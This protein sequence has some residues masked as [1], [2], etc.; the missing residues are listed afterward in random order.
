METGCRMQIANIVIIILSLSLVTTSSFAKNEFTFKQALLLAYQKNPDLCVEIEKANAMKG[1]FIQSGRY[2]NPTVLLEAEN[3]GG[4]G[5]FQGF[6]SAETTLSISQPIPL[7]N[8]L[9]YLQQATLADFIASQ[10][11]ITI[12]KSRLYVSVGTAYVDA[13]Y[14]LQWYQV[15][16]KLTQL[17]QKIVS[18]IKRR[19]KAGV[20]AQLDLKLAQ[21]RLGEAKIQVNRAKRDAEIARSK[22]ER[23]IGNQIARDKKLTHE[24]LPH[25]VWTWALIKKRIDRSPL[26]KE[27]LLRLQAKRATITA[28]KEST[29]P[30]LT[31]Q[32]GA[33][34]FSDDGSNAAVV[35]AS[36]PLPIFDRNQGKI[37]TEEA[38]YSQ[39]TYEIRSLRLELQQNLYTLFLQVQQSNYEAKQI[40]NFLL[41][42]AKEA[43]TLAQEGYQ[44]GR[45]TYIELSNAINA[46]Y[47]EEKD[48]QLA[49]AEK[50]KLSIQI[51]G[52]LGI[53]EPK[54]TK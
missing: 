8:R 49:H 14:A 34:H 13:L 3:I 17:N 53:C 5:S 51:T 36:A 12:Q 35:S 52:M 39:I 7:G 26:L 50:H 54:D 16:K 25:P 19:A 27:K 9:Q 47:E 10:A 2:P 6:E 21:L 42:F 37:H 43:V 28:V 22:L 1:Y 45:Y 41:P 23:V 4:S 44:Q 38:Q 33:R 15:T 11:S 18:E 40:T 24:G 46:L 48:F 20:G 32:V 29:W 31:I 30:N